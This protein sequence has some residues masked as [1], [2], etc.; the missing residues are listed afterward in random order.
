VQI[1]DTVFKVVAQ[2][3]HT[4]FRDRQVLVATM[5]KLE[6]YARE[7]DV[8]SQRLSKYIF[9]NNVY[10]TPGKPDE[11]RMCLLPGCLPVSLTVKLNGKC[12]YGFKEAMKIDSDFKTS[13]KYHLDQNMHKIKNRNW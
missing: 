8:S 7:E 4:E 9:E 13:V 2:K 5:G 6:I 11:A 1:L 10:L 12:L 3:F